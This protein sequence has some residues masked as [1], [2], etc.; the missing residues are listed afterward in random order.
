M[1]HV[2]STENMKILNML[3]VSPIF[4]EMKNIILFP[5]LNDE[6]TVEEHC[7]GV[8]NAFYLFNINLFAHVI[9]YFEQI[10][11]FNN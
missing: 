7:H 8:F 3:I 2:Y 5:K 1:A 10:V 11:I 4:F 6:Y 9:L